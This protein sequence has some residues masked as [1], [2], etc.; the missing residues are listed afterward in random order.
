[1]DV[2]VVTG[3]GRGLGEAIAGR[4]AGRG[5]A[6]LATDIDGESAAATAKK[7]GGG[8]WSAVHDVRDPAASRRIA[9]EATARGRL[10]V[11][12]N[13]AG[14]LRTAHVWDH[15]D[16]DV[17]LLANVNFLGVVHGSRAA[18]EAMRG[19]PGGGRILNLGSLSSLG[20]VP[21]LAVYGATK[22]AV[23]AFSFSLQGELDEVGLPIE[24]RCLCP[25]TTDTRMVRDVA[26]EEEATVLWSAPRIL[27][28]EE[29]AEDAIELLYGRRLKAVKPTY[30]GL[31]ARTLMFAPRPGMR[32][33]RG[34]NRLAAVKRRRWLQQR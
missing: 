24:V 21:N 27:E 11:W 7:L 6:V 22:H 2:A 14:V 19:S 1:M 12:V 10:A 31:V 17:E 18:V 30:R 4:L 8:S 29:V 23:L 20:P 5:L 32:V 13:N 15:P 25:D 26:G 28:V 33:L 9:A 16:A 34:M 3:A